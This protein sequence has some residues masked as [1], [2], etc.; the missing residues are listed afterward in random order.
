MKYLLGIAALAICLSVPSL[1]LAQEGENYNHAEVGAFV[2]Y[3]NYARTHP[4][5]NFFGLGGRAAFN[6]GRYAQIEAEMNYDFKRNFTN[7]ISNGVSTQF[8]TTHLRPLTALFGPKFN[9]NVGGARAFFT[10]K[11][12]F[13]N[14]STT[15]QNPPAGFT[16]AV[17]GIT[18]GNTRPA[19]Y[20]G[21][22]L[23]G[24]W[25]PFGLRFDVGDDIYFDN[26]ARNN[27]RL[28]F[29]PAIRF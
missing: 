2:D 9:T 11:A 23:E 27:L 19:L 25:G 5:I 28:T 17:G 18:T 4:H 10:F 13:V 21:A 8:V 24:F 3:M 6:A 15:T 22:G 29:G 12:G 14:F 1:V 7:E 26:G 20:P 16:T